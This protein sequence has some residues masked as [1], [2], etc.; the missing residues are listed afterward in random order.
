MAKDSEL[1]TGEACL[2][3]PVAPG[4]DARFIADLGAKSAE[5]QVLSIDLTHLGDG[6]L[7][8]D[9]PL[10]WDPKSSQLVSL[11]THIEQYRLHPQ[12]KRGTATALTLESFI[13]LVERHKTT[14]SVVFADTSW[15]K[16][17]FTAVIDYHEEASGGEADHGKHRIHYAFPLS[18]E[19]QAWVKMDGEVMSQH[20][21]AT[22]LE[23][24][25]AELSSPTE[26]EKIEFE[27][28]FS[29]TV[30]TPAEVVRLS[31]SLQVNV[32]SRVKA[33]HTLQNGAGHLAWEETHA[34]SDGKP[35]VVPG[36][37]LLNVAP[38]F[39]GEPIRIPVRLRYRVTSGNIKWFYQMY[40]PDKY[41]T[42]RVQIDLDT[43]AQNSALPAFEG[44][45]EMAA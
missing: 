30:A 39:M 15:R 19:W 13:N 9:V 40:R 20:D 23:D 25:I 28:D 34:D 14:D 18:E 44:T 35:L 33:A 17:S 2:G 32:E 42:E 10:I 24:R 8:P 22:F 36:I 21:F 38:F 37:F 12:F 26:A 16:P 6:G 43:V 27:R 5:A 31:R 7:P 11:K 3:T 1:A 45:P 29:T 41:V 4:F